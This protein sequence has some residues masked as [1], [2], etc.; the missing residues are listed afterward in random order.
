[1]TILDIDEELPNGFHDARLLAIHRNLGD[2]IT[3]LDI[4][5]FVGFPT[6]RQGI[7]IELATRP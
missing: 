7:G 4:E 5:V 3:A 2:G 6:R 1:M